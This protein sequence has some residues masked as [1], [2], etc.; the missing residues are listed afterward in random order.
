[1]IQPWFYCDLEIM[2]CTRSSHPAVFRGKDVMKICCKFTGEHPCQ[3]VIS[4]KLQSNFIEITL[5]HGCSPVNVLHIFRTPFSKNTSG[6]LLPELRMG[7]LILNHLIWNNC[8][9]FCNGLLGSYFFKL[10]LESDYVEPCF[11]RV[12]VKTILAPQYCTNIS[13][14]QSRA[15]DTI[16]RI[17]RGKI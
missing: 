9:E 10:T 6:W 2:A 5:R 4:I 14:F 1:M 12:P 16:R 15:L 3:S 17:C 8:P 13:L 7:K 11:W